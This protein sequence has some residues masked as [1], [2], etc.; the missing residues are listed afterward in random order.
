MQCQYTFIATAV[1]LLPHLIDN[2][3]TVES[4]CIEMGRDRCFLLLYGRI[5]YFERQKVKRSQEILPKDK[6]WHTDPG[7]YQF[8]IRTKHKRTKKANETN[9][10]RTDAA[11]ERY[12]KRTIHETNTRKERT[13]HERTNEMKR[14]E[15]ENERTHNTRNERTIHETNARYTNERIIGA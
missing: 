8:T 10:K 12:E 7:S 13:M 15:N 4:H 11:H 1:P 3:C 6:E 9:E 14:T 5:S 2:S